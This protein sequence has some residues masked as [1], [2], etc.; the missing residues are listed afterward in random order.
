[1]ILIESDSDWQWTKLVPKKQ[2]WAHCLSVTS[3][4]PCAMRLLLLRTLLANSLD[5]L[6]QAVD[7]SADHIGHIITD[8][9][10]DRATKSPRRQI[11]FLFREMSGEE[12]PTIY[13]I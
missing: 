13:F 10:A 9:N 3:L 4:Q 11:S 7:I 6:C 5:C 12:I 2:V 1:M 8:R